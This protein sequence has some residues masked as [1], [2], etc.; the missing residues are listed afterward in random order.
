MQTHRQAGAAVTVVTATVENPHGYGRIVRDPARR[1]AQI[2][3]EKDATPAERQIREIN[4]GI[5]AFELDG[6]FDAVRSIASENAQREYYLPDLVSI[7][8]R[9]GLG[10]ETVGVA[11]A[12]EILGI[13]SRVELA[14]V[15]TIVRQT[16]NA[17]LMAA[18][19]T[20]E[21]PATTYVDAD[22][23]IGADTILHPWRLHR[24]RQR[25]RDR[26]RDP[27]RRAHCRLPARRSRDGVESRDHH[28]LAPRRRR[29]GRTVRARP[30][31]HGHRAGRQDRQLRRAEKDGARPRIE[32][33]ASRLSRRRGDRRTT[34]TSAPAP[35]RATTTARGSR[36]RRSRTVRSLAATRSSSRRSRS[37]QM[38]LRRDRNDG[39]GERAGRRARRQRRETAQHRRLGRKETNQ[40]ELGIQN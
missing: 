37:A 19:V 5:Y 36:R 10:V 25:R 3:E 18:G 14:A 20:I 26:L 6:L 32:I 11:D 34:S 29:V 23:Q 8:R 12:R 27:Q 9:R 17:E 40:E 1:I 24:A 22:V 38:R 15:S 35:S 2:V 13:N 33:N 21:D 39:A 7:Y 4:S 16:K 31:R 28:G 30:Q